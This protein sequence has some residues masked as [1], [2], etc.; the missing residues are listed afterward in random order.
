MQQM[1]NF[2]TWDII[3][4]PN[5]VRDYVGC[6]IRSVVPQAGIIGKDKKLH[7]TDT[8]GC[9]HLSLSLTLLPLDKIAAISQ[10]TFSDAFSWMKSFVFWL[11]FHW[12]LFLSVQLTITQHCFIDNGL[13]SYRRQA[14]IWTNA[15]PIHWRIYAA[16]GRDELIPAYS[17]TLLTYARNINPSC[18]ETAIWLSQYLIMTGHAFTMQC[19]QVLVIHRNGFKINVTSQYWEILQNAYIFYVTLNQFSMPM[20]HLLSLWS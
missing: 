3:Y 15:D 2:N 17:T 7:P 6:H 5:V 13:A 16:L 12:S 4:H 11:I 20:D 14:I 8:V 9:N 18:V 19:K 1:I 10:K